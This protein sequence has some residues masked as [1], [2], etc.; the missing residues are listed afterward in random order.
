MNRILRELFWKIWWNTPWC[1]IN[2]KFKSYKA[3]KNFD[4]DKNKDISIIAVNCVGGEL[5]SIL[6]LKFTSPLINSSLGRN[7]FALLAANFN[8]YMQGDLTDFFYNKRNEL[9]C[10]LTSGNLKP[11]EIGWPHDHSEEEVVEKFMRRVKRINYEKLVFITDE[12]DMT[13]ESYELFNSVNSFKKVVVAGKKCKKDYDFIEKINVDSVQ[14]WQY[15]K[16]SGIFR[17]QTMWNF[18]DWFNK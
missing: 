10:Y 1:A 9:S 12:I 2:R 8:E 7:D 16:L 14:G 18:V 5:Y 13:D 17:F 11:L 4:F 6:G 3:R 15:K